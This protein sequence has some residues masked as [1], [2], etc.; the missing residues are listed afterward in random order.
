MT[1]AYERKIKNRYDISKIVQELRS[2]KPDIMIVTTNGAFDILHSGH[3]TSL[4]QAKSYGDVLIVGLNSDN[5][6]RHY[7][8]PHRPIIPQK[9]R[10]TMLASLEVVDYV[11]IFEETDPC[12]LLKVIKPNYHVKSR[13]GYKGIEKEVVEQNGGEIIL[14]E[15]LPGLSTTNIIEKIREILNHENHS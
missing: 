7:K 9:E 15:D 1:H 8:S 13:S 2:Q 5:S 4:E 11:T 14:L 12:E 3:V 6:I 10:A